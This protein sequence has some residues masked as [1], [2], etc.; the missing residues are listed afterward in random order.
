MVLAVAGSRELG[1]AI[2]KPHARPAGDMHLLSEVTAP[3]ASQITGRAE[4]PPRPGSS[5]HVKARTESAHKGEH[6]SHLAP[7]NVR[8]AYK[9]SGLGIH[10]VQ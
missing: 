1:Q 10:V 7:T 8:H 2:T 5:T 4:A 6:L 9:G 3:L